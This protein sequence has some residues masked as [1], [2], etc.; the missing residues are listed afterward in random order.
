MKNKWLDKVK[1]VI[2]GND[3]EDDYNEIQEEQYDSEDSEYDF[4]DNSS[5]KNSFESPRPTFGNERRQGKVVDFHS[6]SQSQAHPQ[7]H[8]AKPHVVVAKLEKFEDVGSITNSINEKRMVIINLETASNEI[9]QRII[10]FIYGVTIANKS[11]LKR[12]AYRTY[13][14][15]PYGFDYTG[16]SGDDFDGNNMEGFFFDK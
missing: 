11:E 1:N 2:M 15:K 5:S 7:S 4:L 6:A 10:D 8:S 16:N 12:V 3:D 14:I 9:T 13:M